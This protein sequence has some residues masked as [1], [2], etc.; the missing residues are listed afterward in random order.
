MDGG[1]NGKHAVVAYGVIE[2]KIVTAEHT[3]EKSKILI[4]DSNHVPT[5][6]ENCVYAIEYDQM[7][8]SFKYETFTDFKVTEAM[9]YYGENIF[10]VESPINV[11]I[12]N[13]VGEKINNNGLNEIMGRA[14]C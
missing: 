6:C 9:E 13:K 14:L 11:E 2:G 5:D 1:G 10:A 12:T 4:Y 7:C 3:W 8:D